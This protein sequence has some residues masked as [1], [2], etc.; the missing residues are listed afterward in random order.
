M[1]T[2]PLRLAILSSGPPT[3][4]EPTTF[5]LEMEPCTEAPVIFTEDPLMASIE[6]GTDDSVTISMLLDPADA[7]Q[8]RP[9]TP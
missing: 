8:S 6:S 7:T 2:D 3:A 1:T 9:G 4:T 5:R